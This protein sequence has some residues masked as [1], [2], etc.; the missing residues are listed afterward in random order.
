MTT[1]ADHHRRAGMTGGKHDWLP[2]RT[3][4]LTPEPHLLKPVEAARIL[5]ISP[6]TLWGLTDRG[7]IPCIRIGRSV[8][9]DRCD[10]AAWIDNRKTTT[11]KRNGMA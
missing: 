7:D 2:R 8:R 1:T 10:L 4:A 5:S 3:S 9:Y 6:R 11:A